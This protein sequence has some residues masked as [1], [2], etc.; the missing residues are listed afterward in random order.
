M[1]R[2]LLGLSLALVLAAPVQAKQRPQM[3]A[4]AGT[5]NPSALVA[6]EI[7]FA[8]MAREKGQWKAF[9]EFAADDAVMFVPDRVV[10]KDWLARQKD[11]PASVQWQPYQVWMSCDGSAGV[12]KG[13][14]QRPDGSVGWYTTVWQ[15][16]K[17]GVYRWVLDQGDTLAKPLDA[18]EMLSAKVASCKGRPELPPPGTPAADW[19]DGGSGYASDK[20]MHWHHSMKAD[21]TRG[22]VLYLWTGERYEQMFWDTSKPQE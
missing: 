11:P 15:R 17:K 6:E 16:Q 5:A 4:G 18:P 14:W 8:R 9:R 20:T 22:L 13:A 10:A 3:R 7:A 19:V 2:L 21:R 1:K 12:T